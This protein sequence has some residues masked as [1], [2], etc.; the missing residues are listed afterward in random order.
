MAS[1]GQIFPFG[2][3]LAYF[4]IHILGY[5]TLKVHSMSKTGLKVDIKCISRVK[6]AIGII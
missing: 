2:L 5:L 4:Q 6:V 1:R 3:T